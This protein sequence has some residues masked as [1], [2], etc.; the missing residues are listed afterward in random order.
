[1][2]LVCFA[3]LVFT[4]FRMP[5]EHICHFVAVRVNSW[6]H[7]P[8]ADWNHYPTGK[9]AND[10]LPSLEIRLTLFEKCRD[11]FL[12]VLG[13]E[14]DREQIHLASETFVEVGTRR[15]LYSFLT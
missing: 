15:E 2:R 7:P 14:T 8:R 6:S 1:M 9:N 11:A 10:Q 12:F 4:V 3:C 5:L 13:R